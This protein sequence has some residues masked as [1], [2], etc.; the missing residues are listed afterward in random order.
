MIYISHRGNVEGR[1]V[2]LENKPEYIDLAINLGLDVE[3]D[4][5]YDKNSLFWLGHDSPQ[6]KIDFSWI[7]ERKNR[8]WIHCKNLEAITYFNSNRLCNEL[9]YFWH[10]TD[11]VTLTSL[12][13]IWAFPGNQPISNSIAVMPELYDD[14]LSLCLGI[15]SDQ[16]FKY[17]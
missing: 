10:D 4:I 9:N 8:L 12:N 1:K 7:W 16:I 17:K 2:E 6:F 14:D 11:K 13:Y 15:C 5:W 3:V